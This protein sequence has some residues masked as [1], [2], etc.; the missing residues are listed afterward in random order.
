VGG[1]RSQNLV[2]LVFDQPLV[3]LTM[4]SIRWCWAGV[5]QSLDNCQEW[6]GQ[7]S[8]YSCQAVVRQL[9]GSCQ[10][11]VR[12]LSGSCHAVV[13]QLSGSCQAVI[14]LSGMG[15]TV[16][17]SGQAVVTQSLGSR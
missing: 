13:R 2:N 10:T 11:I 5:R 7:L 12:Q 3:C 14:S 1:L 17:S 4:Y 9:S 8:T 6:V 16:V 15:Q